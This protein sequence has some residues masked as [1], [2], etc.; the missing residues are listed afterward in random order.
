MLEQLTSDRGHVIE[1]TPILDINLKCCHIKQLTL[2]NTSNYKLISNLPDI[3]EMTFTELEDKFLL[4]PFEVNGIKGTSAMTAFDFIV[5][6][7]T[8]AADELT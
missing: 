7:T 6:L 8:G 3:P 4:N 2:I 1:H 5:E